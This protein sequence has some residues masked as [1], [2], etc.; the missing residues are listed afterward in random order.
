MSSPA[1]DYQMSVMAREELSIAIK[2]AKAEGWNPGL[3]DADCFYAADPQGFLVGKLHDQPIA[4]ISAVKYGQSFGFIGFYIVHPDFRHQGYGIQ[5]WN[6]ALESLQGR[7]IG[8]DGVVAQ[9][10][11]YKKSGFTFAHR[12][13]RFAGTID[14]VTQPDA[15]IV[16]LSAIDFDLLS[17]YDR[18]FFP[19][20]RDL[21]LRAWIDQPNGH[22]LGIVEGNRLWAYGVIRA[23]HAGYKIGPLNAETPDLAIELFKGLIATLPPA[24]TIYLDVPEPN[25]RA[26][27]LAQAYKM[28]P[29]F[30]TARM[31]VG[32]DPALNLQKIFGISSFELG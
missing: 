17:Q 8:L 21:F 25:S 12:N 6:R 28:Q 16:D 1:R 10:E 15:E 3:H 4:T 26:I 22:A 18:H 24:S 31:Y 5:I 19:A 11:N 14:R 23:C 27:D 7:T 9:Q 13:I 29:A 30:E 32:S 20:R 2:W